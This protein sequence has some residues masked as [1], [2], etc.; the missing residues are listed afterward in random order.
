MTLIAIH[1]NDLALLLLRFY[2]A[3]AVLLILMKEYT[4]PFHDIGHIYVVVVSQ[5]HTDSLRVLPTSSEPFPTSSD[6]TFD[7]SN[8]KIEEDLDVIEESFTAIK[9]ETDIGIKQEESP[10]AITFSDIKSEPEEVSYLCVCLFLDT[11]FQCPEISVFL[12][13][14]YFWPIRNSS[15]VG[16]E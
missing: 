7:V 8:I 11:F 10:E 2:K 5:S 6:G 3:A 12:R 13:R 15:N 16:N 1:F 4:I 9:E 14:Q